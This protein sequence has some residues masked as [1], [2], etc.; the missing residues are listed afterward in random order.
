MCRQ[1]R[2]EGL[3]RC[4]FGD[5]PPTPYL[6]IWMTSPLLIS[7]S[8]SGTVDRLWSQVMSVTGREACQIHLLSSYV[9]FFLLWQ[10]CFFSYSGLLHACARVSQRSG[11]ESVASLNFFRFLFS[12]VSVAPLT[13]M[14]FFAFVFPFHSSNLQN[15]KFVFI[16]SFLV[17]KVVSNHIS[18]KWHIFF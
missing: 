17:W 5:C 15:M 4:F 13:E 12:T 18:Y 2:P 11:F 7:R 3:K 9:L 16:I 6:R 1:V 10:K 14:F 8:G